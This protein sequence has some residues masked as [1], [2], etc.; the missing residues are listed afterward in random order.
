[1]I[2]S[3][4]PTATPG[5]NNDEEEGGEVGGGGREVRKGVLKGE[6]T[7]V[8]GSGQSVISVCVCVCVCVSR[9]DG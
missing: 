1:M 8:V 2:S 9:V 7:V 4:E 6:T 5:I 3:A